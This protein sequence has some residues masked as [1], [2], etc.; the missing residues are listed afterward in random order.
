[1]YRGDVYKRQVHDHAEQISED[2]YNVLPGRAPVAG[3]YVADKVDDILKNRFDVIHRR[4]DTLPPSLQVRAQ[5]GE[6]LADGRDSISHHVGK[7]GPDLVHGVAEIHQPRLYGCLLYTSIPPRSSLR[8]LRRASR[9]ACRLWYR[10]SRRSSL[11][12]YFFRA[13]V[14]LWCRCAAK[15]VAPSHETGLAQ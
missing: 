11:V 3:K 10:A 8:F 9:A 7:V 2:V 4:L 15:R 1:M 12:I 6:F 14:R 13:S 5:H